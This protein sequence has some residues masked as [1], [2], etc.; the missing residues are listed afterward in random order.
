MDSS[1]PIAPPSLPSHPFTVRFWGVRG[2]I[3]TPDRDYME[4]GGNTACV[5]VRVG[6]HCLILDGGTGLR[7]LG[8]HLLQCP[9]LQAH[10]LFTHSHWDRIQGFPFFE[11]AFVP[12]YCFH[13]YGSTAI[14][15]ASIKHRLMN[16]M[17]RPNFPIPLLHMQASLHFHDVA[18]GD[19]WVLP[20]E[21]GQDPVTI[22]T[23]SLNPNDRAMG[24]RI[25][26][27]DRCLVYATDVD[28]HLPGLS[29]GDGNPAPAPLSPN[30][31]LVYLARGADVLIYDAAQ[32]Q[33][34]HSASGDDSTPWELGL[35]AASA[36]QVRQLVL[37]HHSPKDTDRHLTAL[38]Q[39]LQTL[40]PSTLC[41]KEG[42]WLPVG[43]P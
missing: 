34:I 14:N 35:A 41:A 17:V 31:A 12:G 33:G 8:Q 10:V 15:G 42:T 19:C 11:P 21:T 27:G 20:S 40:S 9:P 32:Y 7:S 16:Q 2:S 5:E 26:W 24:Y 22:E 3:P 36:A 18:P 43:Q 37:F 4:F 1:P 29:T 30:P 25:T 38:E 6:E 39:H 13:I 28:H 23:G